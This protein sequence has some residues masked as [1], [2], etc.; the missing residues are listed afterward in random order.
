[1]TPSPQ[2][3]TTPSVTANAATTT[4]AATVTMQ[5]YYYRF[6]HKVFYRLHN[7]PG[8][9]GSP[10]VSNNISLGDVLRFACNSNSNSHCL[11]ALC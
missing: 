3:I 2:L 10:Q 7:T 9:A 4:T 11:Q 6:S 8:Q 5:Y 1:M